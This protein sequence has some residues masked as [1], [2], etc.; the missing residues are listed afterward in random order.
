MEIKNWKR[1]GLGAVTLLSAAVLAACGNSSSSSSSSSDE[2]NWFIPTEISTLDIS[3]V[4]D[5]YS[6]IAIGNSGSNLLRRDEDGKL[7]PD[8]AEKVEVSDDGLT[9]TATLRDDLKWSDGSNLTAED[10][11][12][13]WQRIVDPS[14]ASEY[15]YLVSDAHV[16]NAEEVIAGTKSVDELGVKA[17]GNKL[18]FTLSNP[19]PQ[20]MSLLSFSNFMP[21]SKDFV[22]KAGDDYGTTSE[23]SLYSGPYTV[24]DWNG[25]SGTFTLVKNKYY[26]DAKDVKNK[27]VNIQTIKKP[28]TAVQMYK[29]G[30]LDYANI[31]NTEATYKANKNRD[32]VVDVPEATTAY[33]VYNQTGTVTALNNTKIR[34]ALNLA[35]DREGIV[36]AAIDTGSTAATALVPTGLQT[37]PDGTDLAKYVSPG[38]S[39]DEKE[40]AKLFKEGL[41]E[42]GTDSVTLTITA[43]SDAPVSKAAVDYIKETW[44]NTLSGLTVQEKFVTFKQRLEDTKNQNFDVALVLW[45]GDYPE[46]STFY[47][48]FT[49]NSSY[50]Y[51]KFS[52]ADYDAAYQKAITTDAL[53]P[54]AAADD[55]KAAEKVLY[56]NA[57][58]NPIY[59]RSG[60]GLQN[61]DLKGL[62]RNSTGLSVDF[63]YAYKK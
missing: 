34:Q 50:N 29:D 16:L 26:W 32:D 1:V 7:Q 59:F 8:L 42:L 43:D 41:A 10:F 5:T 55:Y 48:L 49:T 46:G 61:P 27:K 12:Y 18:I 23:K 38:Y 57:P 15:A 58:Y 28:D 39:H 35:T 3:K 31:S 4:T 45:G 14:T 9:Y 30:D 24:E 53:D 36:K 44:E 37:L 20:F 47:G 25:T 19:S 62:V 13:S 22:K 11:V 2:I 54:A 17:D 21:Q 60:K 52:N 63:T 51:G 56:D 6:S 40:A 33:M